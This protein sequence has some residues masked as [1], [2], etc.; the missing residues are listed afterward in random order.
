MPEPRDR[1][2]DW[3]AHQFPDCHAVEVT[4]LKDASPLLPPGTAI[5]PYIT[6]RPVVLF[7]VVE[8]SRSPPWKELAIA[9]EVFA[10]TGPEQLLQ[11]L[12]REGVAQRLRHSPERRLFLDARLR[13]EAL[14]T[15]WTEREA[16]GTPVT[17]G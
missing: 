13:L 15:T 11:V 5:S 1:V 2:R 3:L 8:E 9:R 4:T 12:E 14:G 17:G 10:G 6:G 7:R 16:P